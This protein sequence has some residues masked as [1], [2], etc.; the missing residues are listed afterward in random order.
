MHLIATGRNIKPAEI[1]LKEATCN[2]VRATSPSFIKIKLLPQMMDK[3]I[4]INQLNNLLFAKKNFCKGAVY[5]S[6]F[7][8]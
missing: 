3:S 7:Y 8:R 6:V 5:Y 1:I 2:A 4:K